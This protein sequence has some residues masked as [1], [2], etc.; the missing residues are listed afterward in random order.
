M[1]GNR[2]LIIVLAVIGILIAGLV[3]YLFSDSEEGPAV[4]QQLEIPQPEPEPEAAPEPEPEPEPAPPEA[5]PEPEEPAFVL[6]RLEDSDPLV[7]DGVTS[8]T[9]H[10]GIEP[11][12]DRDQLAR[13]FVVVVDGLADGNL[14]RKP[15]E[16]LA[17][18]EPF[19]A[20]PINDEVFVM[21]E[22]S[23][24]RYDRITDIFVSVDTDRAVEFYELIRP[25]L[26]DAYTELG[27]SS[28]E[29]DETV[30]RAIGRLLETPVIT[31]PIY[32][33]QPGVMYEYQDRKL[34]SLSAAQKQLIRM[35]PKNTRAIQA[36]LSEIAVELRSVVEE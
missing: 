10:E 27:Y 6:P 12:V 18:S 36:K 9:R 1:S 34:E 15:V 21:D 24:R 29:F 11:W 33:I 7:R 26:Q 23:Y 31:E 17:P 4:P 32:L 25:L 14:V 13:K 22:A 19:Q 3:V 8:L 30:F 35:G 5:E 28:R 2:T 16:N 20:T